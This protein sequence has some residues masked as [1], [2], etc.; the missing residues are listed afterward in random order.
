MIPAFGRL[1]AVGLAGTIKYS[2]V[3]HVSSPPLAASFFSSHTKDM[4]AGLW[5]EWH[6]K[7]K[8]TS[9]WIED[10]VRR[11]PPGCG[12]GESFQSWLAQM[13]P[14]EHFDNWFPFSVDGHNF[15]NTKL[16]KPIVSL[17]DAKACW[18]KE[19]PRTQS[20][21]VITVATGDE[22]QKLLAVTR[23]TIEAY[24]TK[25]SADFVALTNTQHSYWHGDKFRVNDFVS[26]YDQTLFLDADLI[27]KASCPDLFRLYP[28][29][30]AMHDD[31]NEN[32]RLTDLS[33]ASN[34]L[35]QVLASQSVSDYPLTRLLNSG[36]VLCTREKNPWTP[37][38][39]PL[40]ELHCAE[41]FWVD[42]QAGDCQIL[43]LEFNLQYWMKDF[44]ERI[45]QAHIVHLANCT[46]DRP[47]AAKRIIEGFYG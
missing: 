47:G 18:L 28:D 8:P 23:P 22:F 42:H 7:T 29:C 15:V 27:V 34:E 30:V 38:A 4:Y 37:P 2:E 36:V 35:A 17:S 26:Q 19:A 41:Q 44:W 10:F 39:Q 11:I 3:G 12:C 40:P 21:L 20:R 32:S 45:P 46:T 31:L 14:S 16:G 1:V 6:T 24:A 33:W 5:D 9:D 43:P 25:C 13:Q